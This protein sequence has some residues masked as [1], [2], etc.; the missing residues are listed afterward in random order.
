MSGDHY[1]HKKHGIPFTTN[2]TSVDSREPHLNGM[3]LMKHKRSLKNAKL[4]KSEVQTTAS[5]NNH[6]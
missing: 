3:Q 4:Y 2:A 6:L 1:H 5:T